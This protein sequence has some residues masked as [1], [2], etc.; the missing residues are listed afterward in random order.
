MTAL[1]ELDELTG[2]IVPFLEEIGLPVRFGTVGGD[3]FV[4]GIRLQHGELVVDITHLTFPGDLLHEGGHLAVM[5]PERRACVDGD[6]GKSAAEEM[7]AIAWS[8]AALVHLD[9][10]PAVV[11]HA[12]GYRGDSASLIENFTNG[13]TFGVPLL[14]WLGMTYEPTQAA[15]HGADP[16]PRMIRW[17]RPAGAGES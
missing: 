2:V 8:Y 5:P 11:F 13:R 14:Q 4:P 12:G 16:Y 1:P 9:L 17:L 15:E 3:S 7:M 10:D 6:A